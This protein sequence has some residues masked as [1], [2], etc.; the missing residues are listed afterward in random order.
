M[1]GEP[2]NETTVVATGLEFPE[3]PIAMADGSVTLLAQET[4]TQILIA[5]YSRDG[6]EIMSSDDWTYR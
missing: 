5:I 2:S 1:T 4:A 3:G 6:S